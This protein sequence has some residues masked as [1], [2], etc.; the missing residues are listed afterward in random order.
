[1]NNS[2][3]LPPAGQE[4]RILVVLDRATENAENV[5]DMI[6]LCIERRLKVKHVEIPRGE[7]E[8]TD[9]NGEKIEINNF[10]DNKAIFTFV[11]A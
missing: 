2:D 11:P 7:F 9:P 6:N 5:A 8:W 3:T 4:S 10:F 1:M